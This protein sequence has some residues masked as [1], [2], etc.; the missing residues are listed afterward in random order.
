M[1]VHTEAVQFKADVKLLDY[2]EKKLSKLDHYF[3]R[4]VGA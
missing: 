1:R 4:I 3:D 2:I